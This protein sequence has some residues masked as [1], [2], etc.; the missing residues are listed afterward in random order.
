MLYCIQLYNCG[1]SVL[2]TTE[3]TKA[4][5]SGRMCVTLSVRGNCGYHGKLFMGKNSVCMFLL[6]IRQ[7]TD[8]LQL[9]YSSYLYTV[10]KK[11]L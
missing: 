10:V 9:L 8:V 7:D 1:N 11:F 3:S 5:K 2:V 4:I 6:E